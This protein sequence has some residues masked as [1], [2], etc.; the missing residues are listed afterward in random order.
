MPSPARR[1]ML[2]LIAALSGACASVPPPASPRIGVQ[3]C[4]VKDELKH[5]FEGTLHKL[6]KLGFEGVELAGDF[7]PFA[8]DAA[9]LRAF[10][11]KAGLKCAGAHTDFDSLA[12]AA[13]GATTAFYQAAGCRNLIIAMDKRAWTTQGAT[14]G[15]AQ[16]A[17]ELSALS[18]QLLPMGLRIGYHNHAEEM[19]GA[20]G[21]TAWDVIATGTPAPVILQQ[22]IGWTTHAGKDPVALIRRYPGRTISAHFKAKSS[23]TNIIGQDRADWR[24]IAAAARTVGGAEWFIVEQEHYPNGMGQVEAV[25]ASLRGLQGMLAPP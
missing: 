6:E 11:D 22:D 13:I 4:S 24:A 5:D 17:R 25:A 16:V 18:A 12:P 3:L 15:A 7:G 23:A 10:L 8:N 1:L 19:A 2:A 9:G 21:K 14:Q 20:D